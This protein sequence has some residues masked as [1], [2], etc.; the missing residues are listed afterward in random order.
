MLSTMECSMNSL[1]VI[2]FLST[3]LYRKIKEKNAQYILIISRFQSLSQLSGK[4]I[5]IKNSYKK[6]KQTRAIY[7]TKQDRKNKNKISIQ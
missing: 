2:T 7:N 3:S 1:N 4:R 5:L 6:Y